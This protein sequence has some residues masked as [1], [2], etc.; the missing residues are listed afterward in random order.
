MLSLVVSQPQPRPLRVLWH[1]LFKCIYFR[2]VRFIYNWY[3]HTRQMDGNSRDQ[4]L[5]DPPQSSFVHENFCVWQAKCDSSMAWNTQTDPHTYT[6]I[7]WIRE[8]FVYE[9][10][11]FVIITRCLAFGIWY[12]VFFFHCR[13]RCMNIN[14][15][16]FSRRLHSFIIVNKHNFSIACDFKCSSTIRISICNQREKMTLTYSPAARTYVC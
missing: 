5:T 2:W 13:C 3:G 10:R 6:P 7:K 11:P 9:C 12:W 1:C 15:C 16:P 4:Q 8:R 14:N